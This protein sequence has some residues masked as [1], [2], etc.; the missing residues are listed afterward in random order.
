MLQQ[1]PYSSTILDYTFNFNNLNIFNFNIFNKM[2]P[3]AAGGGGGGGRSSSSST[4]KSSSSLFNIKVVPPHRDAFH[5]TS[6]IMQYANTR[7]L[8]LLQRQYYYHYN[9]NQ[10]NQ[11]NLNNLNNQEQEQE[12]QISSSLMSLSGIVVWTFVIIGCIRML[13]IKKIPDIFSNNNNNKTN[14]NSADVIIIIANKLRKQNTNKAKKKMKMMPNFWFNGNTYCF[15]LPMM[16]SLVGDFIMTI[17]CEYHYYYYYYYKYYYKNQDNSTDHS[18]SSLSLSLSLY[19]YH[20]KYWLSLYHLLFL[21]LVAHI[22]AFSFTLIF[23]I[24]DKNKNKKNNKK[25]KLDDNDD[26]RSN[27]NMSTIFNIRTLYWVCTIGVYALV[28]IGIIKVR[29][30][31][32]ALHTTCTVM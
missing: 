12:E 8:L 7:I 23:R 11:N 16:L 18:S 31:L 17:Y 5:R 10:N 14:S 26:K 32:Q 19:E 13:P 28:I 3:G 27:R 2:L 15:V 24:R 30:T 9:Y 22:I 6:I 25:K 21:Q 29:N 1:S 20:T 4:T